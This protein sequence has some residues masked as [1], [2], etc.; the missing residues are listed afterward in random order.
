M[1]PVF[2]SPFFW[3]GFLIPILIVGVCCLVAQEDRERYTPRGC[4]CGYSHRSDEEDEELSPS[5]S[6]YDAV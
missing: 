6:R 3:F 5:R 2:S 1:D 4:P